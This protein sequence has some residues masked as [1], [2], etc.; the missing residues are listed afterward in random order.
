MQAKED[1]ELAAGR[2]VVREE[3]MSLA[4]HGTHWKETT[5]DDSD[6]RLS[7]TRRGHLQGDHVADR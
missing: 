2:R 3:I 1:A 4:A 6:V 5:S 7:R